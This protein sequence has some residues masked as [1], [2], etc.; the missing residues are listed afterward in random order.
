LKNTSIVLLFFLLMACR[1]ERS[2]TDPAVRLTISADT[3]RFDTVFTTTGSITQVLKIFNN[4]NASIHVASIQLL[5][6]TASPFK[7]NANGALGPLVENLDIDAG[8]SAYV[9][10]IVTVPGTAATRPFVVQDS[11]AISYN[12]NT[13]LVQLQAY[14]QNAHFLR[15]HIVTGTEVWNADLPY[16]LLDTFVIASGA[17]LTINEGCRIY[18]H[19]NAPI[20]VAGQLTVQGQHWD[21]TRVLFTG[22]RLD[23]PYRDVPGSWPGIIF[24]P[25]S[26]DNHIQYGVLK[27]AVQ[28]IDVEESAISN[29]LKLS[30][31]IIDNAS[32]AGIIA[33]NTSISAQNLLVSNCGRNIVLQNGGNY[34]FTQATIASFSTLYLPHK[35]PVLTITNYSDNNTTSDLRAVFRN[36]IFWGESGGVV[37]E[38]VTVQKQG[39]ANFDVLFDG[40]LWPLTKVPDGATVTQPP[41]TDDPDFAV[42][43]PEQKTYDFHLKETS[44]ARNSGVA[45]GVSLDLDGRPRPA[46]A[47]DLGAYEEQ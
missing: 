20:V 27:N 11:L 47:P 14:G 6:G 34:D 18:M 10:V 9:F 13:K 43:D 29:K 19:A 36:C 45:S 12:G 24:K 25:S 23:E 22:D 21:S 40:V 16:V 31:T 33:S 39:T 7:I 38:E 8:D 4:N 17:H 46:G 44:P 15:K 1:K 30:E 5:G 28:A 37:P 2:T 41:V 32:D 3:L 35:Q 26:H 42:V